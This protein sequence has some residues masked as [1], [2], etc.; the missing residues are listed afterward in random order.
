[1]TKISLGLIETWGYVPAIE[2]ADAGARAADITI[3]GYEVTPTGLVAVKFIGDLAAV[4]ASVGAARVF[5]AKIGKVVATQIPRSVLQLGI[6]PPNQP[7]EAGKK[8]PESPPPLA[9]SK[10][11]RVKSPK[12][13]VGK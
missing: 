5:A 10:A 4:K 3:L 9:G 8:G 12:K 2:A 1:M 6:K 11:K 7:T 13:A